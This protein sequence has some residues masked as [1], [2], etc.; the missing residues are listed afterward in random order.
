MATRMEQRR[1]SAA[2]WAASNVILGDG[3]IGWDKTNGDMKVGDG[4]TAWNALPYNWV[5]KSLI[6]ATGDILVGNGPNSV[7]KL[8]RGLTGQQL[9]VAADGTLVWADTG[10]DKVNKVGDTMTGQLLFTLNANNNPAIAIRDALA[11]GKTMYIRPRQ[12][13]GGS[14]LDFINN[15][16]TAT[17]LSLDDTGKLV[18]A[19]GIY[20][21]VNRV[22]SLSNPDITRVSK[23]G[24]TM[25][26][27]LIF[28]VDVGVLLGQSAGNQAAFYGD[29][30]TLYIRMGQTGLVFRNNLDVNKASVDQ[31][32]RIDGTSLYDNGNRVYSLSNP[33]TTRVNKAGDTMTDTLNID[34]AA[35]I[36][37][38]VGD[39]KELSSFRARDNNVDYLIT[40]LKRR[41]AGSDWTGVDLELV[42]KVDA[43]E[44]GGIALRGDGAHSILNLY[45]G[46]NRVY[47][48]AN[49]PPSVGGSVI[50]Q[51]IR[52]T[53]AN[54]NPAA[55]IQTS[56]VTIASVNT[57]KSQLRHLGSNGMSRTDSASASAGAGYSPTL[58]L[59]NSTTITAALPAYSNSM[60]VQG[61]SVTSYELTEWT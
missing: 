23:A 45:E 26:G 41:I 55:S 10:A 1:G 52:G 44:Q 46:N 5:L 34:I 2:E 48:A 18:A 54:P 6:D 7:V 49:P 35:G 36:G 33:D 51:T 39:L 53:I 27:A 50:N 17:I 20:D 21:G 59:T 14:G 57:A 42:R 43:S 30:T 31:N 38:N 60:P 24:D 15:A 37:V 11:G 58:V 16:Y 8:P 56:T 25:T 28:P 22:Y 3:E 4:V 40:R 9:T 12:Q 32:G 19:G 13:S 47:S 61:S 29:L